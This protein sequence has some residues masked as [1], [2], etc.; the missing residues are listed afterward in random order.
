[1][2][3]VRY[4]CGSDGKGE[5]CTERERGKKKERGGGREGLQM[6]AEEG[7]SHRWEGGDECCLYGNSHSRK[8]LSL[9]NGRP[10]H[11]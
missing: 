7:T 2:E 4:V 5:S 11:K 6:A 9:H 10:Y 8:E 1:M 3:E